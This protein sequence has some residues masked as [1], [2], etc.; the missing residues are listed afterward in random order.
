[1]WAKISTTF[2]GRVAVES[3]ILKVKKGKVLCVN[4]EYDNNNIQKGYI[5]FSDIF[6]SLNTTQ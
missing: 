2:A 4:S 1:M 6:C 3:F 5:I